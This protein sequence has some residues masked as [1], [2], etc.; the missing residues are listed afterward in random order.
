MS[1][2][3]SF[4]DLPARAR[5]RLGDPW[6][7][8]AA[9]HSIPVEELRDSQKAVLACFIELGPMDFETMIPKYQTWRFARDWPRQSASGLRT[10]TSELVKAGRLQNSGEVTVL[11]SGRKAIIWEVIPNG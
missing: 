6:T 7:S 10:R 9:A 2:Q 3:M 8:H 1:D 11:E 4:D 5:A